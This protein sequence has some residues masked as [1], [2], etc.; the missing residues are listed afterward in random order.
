VMS[1]LSR[2]LGP[3]SRDRQGCPALPPRL[4]ECAAADRFY[5]IAPDFLDEHSLVTQRWL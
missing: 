1:L 4:P 5:G 2:Q 3:G